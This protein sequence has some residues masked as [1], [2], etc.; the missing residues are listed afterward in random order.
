WAQLLRR[1]PDARM[2]IKATALLDPIAR[3]RM[4]DAF[5]AREVD[6]ARLHVL[7]PLA[8]AAEHL[9]IYA[10]AD[11]ALDT[12]PYHGTT[13]TC[14]ALYMGVPVVTLA[15]QTHVSRVGV[16]LLH[17]VGLEHLVAQ[18]PQQYV[19]IATRL[20]EDREP[21][22][23]LRAELRPRMQSSPLFDGR[24]LAGEMESA[25]RQAWQRWCSS[26]A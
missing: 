4:N 3:Q 19:E 16:S 22:S 11:V 26:G 8:T 20:S 21:L 24:G 2:I 25:F 23:R 7:G 13:T 17:T 5:A 14:D 9:S 15:G 10:R 6:P 1:V 18:T 12:F